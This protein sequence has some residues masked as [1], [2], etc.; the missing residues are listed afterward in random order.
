V[1]PCVS[2]ATFYF[3]LFL[4]KSGATFLLYY[5]FKIIIETFL[6]R[7]NDIDTTFRHTHI[8]QKN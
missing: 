5:F 7:H 4:V 3:I 1:F 6:H 8:N 2:G